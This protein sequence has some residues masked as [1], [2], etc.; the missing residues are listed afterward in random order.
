MSRTIQQYWRDIRSIEQTL[1][2]LVWLVGTAADA[3]PFVTQV[4]SD[5]AAKWL[6]AKSHRIA[7]DDEVQ[8][9]SASD[10]QTLK[11]AIAGTNAPQGCSPCGGRA[12]NLRP[13]HLHGVGVKAVS[14]PA[15]AAGCKGC[16]AS[17]SLSSAEKRRIV[18]ID[19][20]IRNRAIV[21]PHR[22]QQLFAAEHNPGP[23]HQKFQ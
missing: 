13:S 4:A 8:A 22:I 7:T 15:N 12:A 18:D 6:H 2:A 17:A 21:A 1:P 3:P 9:Q 19:R 23:A 10:V 16:P 14:K 5:I 11:Q 20:A